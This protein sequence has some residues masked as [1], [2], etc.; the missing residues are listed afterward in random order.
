MNLH[1]LTVKDVLTVAE[2]LFRLTLAGL[3]SFAF[4]TLILGQSHH[5]VDMPFLLETHKFLRQVV[6]GLGDD[7]GLDS[8]SNTIHDP[9]L[10]V[11]NKHVLFL[12]L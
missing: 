7:L 11:V 3:L 5:G 6:H 2:Y 4:T 10:V 8:L 1:Q 9:L 12:G